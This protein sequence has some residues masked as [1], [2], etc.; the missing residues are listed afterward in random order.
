[1]T[2]PDEAATMTQIETNREIVKRDGKLWTAEE[3]SELERLIAIGRNTLEIAQAMGRTPWSIRARRQRVGL[4]TGRRSYHV[5]YCAQVAPI[6]TMVAGHFQVRLADMRGPAQFRKW[7]W[8]RQ[9][10]MWLAVKRGDSYSHV[11]RYFRRDH[12]TVMHAE[13]KIEARRRHDDGVRDLTDRLLAIA[14]EN[15][16]EAPPAAVSVPEPLPTPEPEKAASDA[17]GAIEATFYEKIGGSR[18]SREFLLAQNQRFAAAMLS[19]GEWL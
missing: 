16:P 4:P 14:L 3:E 17:P 18:N 11:G 19:S 8:P 2:Q 9:I 1:M 10:A 5:R 13:T 15:A 6:A 12:T 7:Y